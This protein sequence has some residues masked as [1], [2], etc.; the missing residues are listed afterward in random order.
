M[1]EKTASGRYHFLSVELEWTDGTLVKH[2]VRTNLNLLPS[3]PDTHVAIGGRLVD[4]NGCIVERHVDRALAAQ[5]L[6]SWPI[7]G[8]HGLSG[9]AFYAAQRAAK[10]LGFANWDAAGLAGCGPDVLSEAIED[11]ESD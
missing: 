4:G 11:L 1:T 7:S 3:P 8:E 9:L 6:R 2:Q 5:Q 10:R